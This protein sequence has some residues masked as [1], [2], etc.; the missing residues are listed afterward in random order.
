M[1]AL[2]KP[3]TSAPIGKQTNRNTTLYPAVHQFGISSPLRATAL[4][5]VDTAGTPF[6]TLL[7][8][9]SGTSLQSLTRV[10]Y[11]IDD[12]AL[13]PGTAS[14]VKFDAKSGV[15]YHIAVEG[16]LPEFTDESSTKYYVTHGPVTLSWNFTPAAANDLFANA[17]THSGRMPDR[18]PAF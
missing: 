14:R 6:D 17:Q 11:S 8:V 12:A 7:I 4:L 3:L 16:Q 5:T 13:T 9:Y 18:W 15:T 1:A 2:F 10:A